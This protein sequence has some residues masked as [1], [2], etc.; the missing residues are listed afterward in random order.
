[1]V[2]RAIWF[3]GGILALVVVFVGSFGINPYSDDW[4]ALIQARD[5]V[6]AIEEEGR[7]PIILS[8]TGVHWAPGIRLLEDA[9]YALVRSTS[10]TVVRIYCMLAHG[11]GMLFLFL[12]GRRLGLG[13]VACVVAMITFAFHQAAVSPIF[14][15][16]MSS[17]AIGTALVWGAI[18]LLLPTTQ[19]RQ[20]GRRIAVPAVLF[21]LALL[22]KETSLAFL[23]MAGIVFLHRERAISRQA[24]G[25][26]A[27]RLLPFLAVA[28]G[29]LAVRA[30]MGSPTLQSTLGGEAST[31]YRLAGPLTW[32]H[33]VLRLGLATLTPLSTVWWFVA[34]KQLEL[35]KL[36]LFSGTTILLGAAVVLGAMEFVK[37]GD[38]GKVL[39]VLG[40]LLASW[41][42]AL[43]MG[44]VAESYTYMGLLF[45]GLLIGIAAQGLFSRL[46]DT[47]RIKSITYCGLLILGLIVPMH[48][49]SQRSK[50]A[51]MRES[52]EKARFWYGMMVQAMRDFPKGSTIAYYREPTND[53]AYSHFLEPRW[54]V[55]IPEGAVEWAFPGQ[56]RFPKWHGELVDSDYQMLRKAVPG[57][58][59]LSRNGEQLVVD[60]PE[61]LGNGS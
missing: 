46:Q 11:G 5:E 60:P 55:S 32:G 1:V 8:T 27:V 13:A 22:C 15:Y 53:L 7:W 23:P 16:D 31:R 17:A 2:T 28:L 34:I 19:G 38:S 4:G 50:L 30:A 26:I 41:F 36:L 61:R 21:A 57:A 48:F 42:P 18:F 29:F 20:S 25:R 51:L 56:F 52:G 9:S 59:I 58:Y 43:L 10:D 3:L 40:L 12:F 35:G 6:A 45:V 47:N 39:L 49:A 54:Y 24:T 33:N 44:H 37:K 14:A